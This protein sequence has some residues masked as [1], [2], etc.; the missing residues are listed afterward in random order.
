MKRKDVFAGIFVTLTLVCLIECA[1]RLFFKVMDMPH[2]NTF[3]IKDAELG[4]KLKPNYHKKWIHINSRGFRGHETSFKKSARAYRIAALG[5]SSTFGYSDDETSPYPFQ[6]E[7]MLNAKKPPSCNFNFE[8]INAGVEKYFSWQILKHFEKDVL[9]LKPDV[10]IVYM[11]WNDLYTINPETNTQLD[12]QSAFNKII[13]KSLTLRFLTVFVYRF[14]LPRFEKIAP[15]RET[16]YKS[17]K[18]D[19]FIKNYRVLIRLA[20]KN[21]IPVI[22]VTLPSLLGSKNLPH[23]ARFL[24]FPYF[25]HNVKLLSLLWQSYNDTIKKIAKEENVT[26]IA[27]DEHFKK[28]SGRKPL[29]M[30][31]LHPDPKGNTRI[32]AALK[33]ALTKEKSFPCSEAFLFASPSTR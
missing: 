26:L 11:G 20:Q 10:V 21:H 14:M 2:P 22:V 24:H 23:Y 6:L 27:L 15:E 4:W 7:K 16:A 30:D 12:P 32:A 1:P 9:P 13:E 18:P 31:T 29:F 8:V 3:M 17:F 33:D 5:E 19:I 28:L 25:T